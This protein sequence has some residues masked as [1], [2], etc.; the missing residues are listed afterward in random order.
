MKPSEQIPAWIGKGYAIAGLLILLLLPLG[1]VTGVRGIDL[2]S[3]KF[4]ERTLLVGAIIAIVGT[5][6][7]LFSWRA[8]GVIACAA[9]SLAGVGI[10]LFR[11]SG[12]QS[13]AEISQ[14]GKLCAASYGLALVAGIV[15]FARKG[16]PKKIKHIPIEYKDNR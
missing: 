13:L 2:L 12:G 16:D 7:I 8:T 5:V 1:R 9:I 4:D 6:G 11:L 3:G 10:F 14:W 15:G